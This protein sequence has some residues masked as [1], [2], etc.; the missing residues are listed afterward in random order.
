MS[1]GVRQRLRCMCV[2]VVTD[3][4]PS[5]PS[6][7]TAGLFLSPELLL[8]RRLLDDT[9][10]KLHA[11]VT[12]VG[13]AERQDAV[14]VSHAVH[15]PE[16]AFKSFHKVTWEDGTQRGQYSMKESTDVLALL[17]EICMMLYVWQK[18]LGTQEE[19]GVVQIP[20]SNAVA[21]EQQEQEGGPSQQRQR[22]GDKIR[23]TLQQTNGDNVV[24]PPQQLQTMFAQQPLVKGIRAYVRA[25]QRD[26]FSQMELA[27]DPLAE[28]DAVSKVFGQALRGLL[29]LHQLGVVSL[30]AKLQNQ[31]V[32]TEDPSTTTFDES[33][34]CTDFDRSICLMD[35]HGN[36]LSLQT[37]TDCE[38]EVWPWRCKN[39]DLVVC[40]DPKTDAD[41]VVNNGNPII[42]I[43]KHDLGRVAQWMGTVQRHDLPYEICDEDGRTVSR[44]TETTTCYSMK[45][46]ES[47]KKQEPFL[48][49]HASAHC[50]DAL[51]RA[52][53]NLFLNDVLCLYLNVR[54]MGDYR[55]QNSSTGHVRHMDY[56]MPID[57]QLQQVVYNLANTQTLK[58]YS[59]MVD[60]LLTPPTTHPP[61][62][63]L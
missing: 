17:C 32:Y 31:L 11:G 55:E 13:H 54:T 9:R 56:D 37:I 53:H 3:D 49:G 43:P 38:Q 19:E 48:L 60:K 26:A 12:M 45:A 25:F 18:C 61:L 47:L 40:D 24:L 33:I 16:G 7:A 1:C 50:S 27:L 20:W 42:R 5:V 6:A 52:M 57:A 63:P 15:Q 44:G 2:G 46:S 14:Q 62:P 35:S 29:R 22:V 8:R 59:D 41:R 36:A 28:K 51:Q 4:Q 34:I 23:I 10:G 30:D 39:D 58:A 21:T